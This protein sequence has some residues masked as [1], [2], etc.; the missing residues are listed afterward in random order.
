MS[1]SPS[2][3]WIAL[4]CSRRMNSRCRLSSSPLTWDWIRDST[5]NTS[6]SWRRRS[7]IRRRRLWTSSSSSACCRCSGVM[8]RLAAMKSAREEGSE[9]LPTAVASSAGSASDISTTCWKAATALRM[10]A[11]ASR[12]ALTFSSSRSTR[13]RIQGSDWTSSSSRMRA[14][15]WMMACTEPSGALAMRTMVAATPTSCRSPS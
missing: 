5:S 14:T 1:P 4:I 7:M 9:T 3:F 15:P 2:S 10:S 12:S 13:A 6:C 8:L 11:S